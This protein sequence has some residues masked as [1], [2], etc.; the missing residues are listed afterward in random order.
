MDTLVIR[1]GAA[2]LTEAAWQPDNG[3]FQMSKRLRWRSVAAV[4]IAA[5]VA[6]TIAADQWLR[7]TTFESI[8]PSPVPLTGL[9]KDPMPIAVT[10]SA[11]GQHA[12]WIA[13][14]QEVRNSVELWKRMYLEDWNGV[15]QVSTTCC[16][17][18]PTSLTTL[19]HG[20]G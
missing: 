18:T 9:F 16:A 11:A 20:T 6:V 7:T 8:P 10:V 17:A 1:A 4:A 13:T 14:E 5:V 19:L 15:R 2:A 3:T 12:P